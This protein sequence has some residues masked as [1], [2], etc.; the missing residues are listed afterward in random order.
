MKKFFI[1]DLL[2][3][4]F[5][6]SSGIILD[7]FFSNFI[8][9]SYGTPVFY[10]I[11]ILS[12][13]LF[14]ASF[15]IIFVSLILPLDFFLKLCLI[16]LFLFIISKNLIFNANQ[17]PKK[18]IN[19]TDSYSF[20]NSKFLEAKFTDINQNSF[21]QYLRFAE[22][23]GGEFIL[24]A[25][26]STRKDLVNYLNAFCFNDSKEFFPSIIGFNLSQKIIQFKFAHQPSSK[27]L[28]IRDF[29]KDSFSS[30]IDSFLAKNYLFGD[31]FAI[32]DGEKLLVL[33]FKGLEL[34]ADRNWYFYYKRELLYKFLNKHYGTS[35]LTRKDMQESLSSI[36]KK[37][38][39][40]YSSAY[41]FNGLYIGPPWVVS[42]GWG[43]WNF[44]LADNLTPF[45]K[46][47]RVLDLGSNSGILPIYMT[48]AGAKEVKGY[49]YGKD[50]YSIFQN[51]KK[52]YS[53]IMNLSPDI[54][55]ENKNM[56]DVLNDNNVGYDVMTAFCS[57]Y[58]LE[59]QQIEEILIW[60]KNNVKTLIVETNEASA[61]EGRDKLASYAYIKK[62]ILELGFKIELECCPKA[63]DRPV[64]IASSGLK[65][66]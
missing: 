32:K 42:H 53:W 48:R 45:I 1:A 62:L 21:F 65:K 51:Y 15:V 52:I 43:R 36:K 2:K 11:K 10:L 35:F 57:L 24:E 5:K 49:E 30:L 12:S 28:E 61:V 39:F 56:L 33:G 38:N 44:I 23:S 55:I 7:V 8:N 66:S 63:Y 34:L 41:L 29:K 37:F 26:Y 13:D 17:L 19:L 20:S 14:I 22:L 47:K 60:A 27:D 16:A 54:S 9:K 46:G 3:L 64:I 18:L 59:P 40:I 4:P 31:I 6:K 50:E 58:Y 25:K